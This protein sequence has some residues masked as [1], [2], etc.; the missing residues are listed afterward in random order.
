MFFTILPSQFMDDI[1]RFF[2]GQGGCFVTL[3]VGAF[4]F[5]GQVV[6]RDGFL[7]LAPFPGGHFHM[8][9]PIFLFNGDVLVHKA[10]VFV[11]STNVLIM[12]GICK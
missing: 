7:I 9:V 4:Q 12:F 2:Y 3:F 1:E 6:C 10:D 5:A 8:D 11:V